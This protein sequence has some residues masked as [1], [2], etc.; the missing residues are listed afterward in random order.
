M[1]KNI[2]DT[3]NEFFQLGIIARTHCP[4]DAESGIEQIVTRHRLF[5]VPERK[6]TRVSSY[7]WGELPT[8]NDAK[9]ETVTM[10]VIPWK[11]TRIAIGYSPLRNTL[12][13]SPFWGQWS[14]E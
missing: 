3:P 14:V 9:I 13:V 11:D 1:S 10:R 2:I 8:V 12:Y 4:L 5:N 6:I 7:S